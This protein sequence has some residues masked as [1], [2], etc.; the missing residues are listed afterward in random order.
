MSQGSVCHGCG[1]IVGRDCFNPG[2]C[3]Q[4]TRQMAAES[5]ELAQQVYHDGHQLALADEE[6]K[7]L[8]G[9]IE[10]A[11]QAPTWPDCL[12]VLHDALAGK[13]GA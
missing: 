6:I 13:S 2:E 7:R 11:L 12:S 5:T 10:Y 9:M 3:E 4:I 1:G 8:R